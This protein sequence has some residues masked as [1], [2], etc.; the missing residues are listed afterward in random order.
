M[1]EDDDSDAFGGGRLAEAGGW[2]DLPLYVPTRED[3]G[4][5]AWPPM[6]L[7]VGEIAGRFVNVT[8]ETCFL[9]W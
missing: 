1:G 7:E 2:I 8:H 3:W 9:F 4:G 6:H 5:K